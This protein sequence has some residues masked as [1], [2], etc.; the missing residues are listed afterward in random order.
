MNDSREQSWLH[1]FSLY[2]QALTECGPG[3]VF[4]CRLPGELLRFH[5]FGTG[6]FYVTCRPDGTVVQMQRLTLQ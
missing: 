5:F 2:Q 3:M 1:E 6:G 4:D